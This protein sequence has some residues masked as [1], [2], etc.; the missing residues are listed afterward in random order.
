MKTADESRKT[1][2]YHSLNIKPSAPIGY[3]RYYLKQKTI[4]F[5]KIEA[6]ITAKFAKNAKHSREHQV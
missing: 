6:L 4:P 5:Q 3:M 1:Q 2:I